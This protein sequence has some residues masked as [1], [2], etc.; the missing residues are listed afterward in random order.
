MHIYLHTCTWFL[1]YT[2]IRHKPDVSSCTTL[3]GEDCSTNTLRLFL[4]PYKLINTASW[5][6]PDRS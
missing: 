4:A 3:T 5:V 1:I 2:Q 6:V